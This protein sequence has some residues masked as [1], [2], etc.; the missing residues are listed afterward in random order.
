M[1][2]IRAIKKSCIKRC[3]CKFGILVFFCSL[4]TSTVK[5]QSFSF[6]TRRWGISIGNS[7]RFAGIRLNYRDSRVEKISGINITLWQ[8][9]KDNMDAIVQGI[10]FGLIPGAG[11]LRGIQLGVLGV[12][13]EKDLKGVSVGILGVGSGGDLS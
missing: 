1:K 9:R 11:Y 10:S 2:T 8:P 4:G 12:V 13:A 6:P 5:A 3:I 7:Q